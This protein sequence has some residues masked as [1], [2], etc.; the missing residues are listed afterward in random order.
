[1]RIYGTEDMNPR[2]RSLRSLA[3]WR[4]RGKGGDIRSTHRRAGAARARR[5]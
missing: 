2:Y 5:V 3:S 1:M 4:R